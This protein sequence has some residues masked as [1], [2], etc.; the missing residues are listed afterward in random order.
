M[1]CPLSQFCSCLPE[2]QQS[3]AAEHAAAPVEPGRVLRAVARYQ[4]QPQSPSH[5]MQ[6]RRARV[7]AHT[8]RSYPTLTC[9][10]T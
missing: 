7:A 4:R 3:L 6:T 2:L 1:H 10:A 8:C 9:R 5:L